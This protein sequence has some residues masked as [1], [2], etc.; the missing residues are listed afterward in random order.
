MNMKK[1][2]LIILALIV[3][4][5]LSIAQD[6]HFSQFYASPILINPGATGSFEGNQRVVTNFKDQWRGVTTPFKTFSLTAD[7]NFNKSNSKTK[8]PAIGASIF[9]D[10]AGDSKFS[11]TQLDLFFAYKVLLNSKSSIAVGLKSG[12]SQSSIDLNNLRWDSQYS[13]NSGYDLSNVETISI[14]NRLYGNFGCGM[15]YLYMTKKRNMASNDGFLMKL[16]TSLMNINSNSHS[17]YENYKEFDNLKGT[18]YGYFSLGLKNTNLAIQP[19]FIAQRQYAL[20]E[21]TYGSLVRYRLS[22]KSKYTGYIKESALSIGLFNRINDAFIAVVQYEV[23]EWAIGVSYDVNF[24]K[25]N[26][27][28][29]NGST[30]IFIRFTNPNPFRYGQGNSLL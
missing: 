8:Y 24:S 18:L 22:E 26:Q 6:I 5:N 30:E 7:M 11:K 29:S 13:E 9:R 25:L 4:A 10:V 14:D 16:G 15:E 27:N 3:I 21:I 19:S 2:I 17:Y 28:S 12:I 23:R 1:M 20:Q